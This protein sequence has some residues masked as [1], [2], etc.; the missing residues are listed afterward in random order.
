MT[1]YA[2]KIY[3]KATELDAAVDSNFICNGMQWLMAEQKSDGSFGAEWTTAYVVIAILECRCED[4]N[5]V[6]S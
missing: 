5:L 4:L 1:A 6:S 2:I 3:C